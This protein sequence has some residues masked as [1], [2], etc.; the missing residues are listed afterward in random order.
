MSQPNPARTASEHVRS[1]LTRMRETLQALDEHLR[2]L[3]WRV[4]DWAVDV[5]K[6]GTTHALLTLQDLSELDAVVRSR[7]IGRRH[8]RI[9]MMAPGLEVLEQAKRPESFARAYLD[10][11]AMRLQL[12]LP[13]TKVSGSDLRHSIADE[14]SPRIECRLSPLADRWFIVTTDVV[15]AQSTLG[16]P[17]VL[18]Q[19]SVIADLVRAGFDALWASA[20]GPELPIE[21]ALLVAL[22]NG[23]TVEAAARSVGISPRTAHRRLAETMDAYGAKSLFALGAAWQHRRG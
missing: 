5:Q 11:P 7:Y 2:V 21:D 4:D 1:E 16:G 19:N 14:F 6:T 3:P 9:V 18:V 22:G 13:D 8:E 23:S 20:V 12:L 10:N 15:V 17:F